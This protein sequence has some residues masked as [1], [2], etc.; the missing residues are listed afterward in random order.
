MTLKY[1]DAYLTISTTPKD[2]FRN[3]LQ[4]VINAQFDN[5]PNYYLIEEEE[6]FGTLVF[7]DTNVRI[8][9]VI[10]NKSTGEKLGD[11]FKQ[12][13]FKELD[14]VTG[15][16]YRY[17]FDNNI[18]IGVNSTNYKDITASITTRRCNHT[19]KWYD[20]SR[21]LRQEPCVIEYFKSGTTEN[22]S[23]NNNM[24]VP[25]KQCTIILQNNDYSDTL[26]YDQRFFFNKVAWK[27]IGFD[28]ITYSGL[29]RLT[30]E[31][32]SIDNVKDDLTN[33]IANSVVSATPTPGSMMW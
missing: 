10:K 23:E 4:A 3:N 22:I 30:V 33:E 28:R 13:I 29:I 26:Q 2:S 9:Q 21:V 18:W 31:Q 24:I 1:Y 20:T 17:R 15:M 14:H 8:T 11:D 25:S 27:I 12:I 6:T 16:G 32:H 7:T 5:A 19:L